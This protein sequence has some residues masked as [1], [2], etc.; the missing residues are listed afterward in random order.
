[1]AIAIPRSVNQQS[2]S[3][4]SNT[5]SGASRKGGKNQGRVVGVGSLNTAHPR[6][7]GQ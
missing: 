5:K 2:G 7:R 3:G 1:M 6:K 4:G